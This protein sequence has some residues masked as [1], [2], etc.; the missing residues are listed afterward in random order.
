MILGFAKAVAPER[1]GG[2]C[3]VAAPIASLLTVRYVGVSVTVTEP[4]DDVAVRN[5]YGDSSRN[6]TVASSR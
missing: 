4:A 5:R 6:T 2:V 1:H 3:G